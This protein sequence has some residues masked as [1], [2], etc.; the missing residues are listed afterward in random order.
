LREVFEY[1]DVN[2]C[3]VARIPRSKVHIGDRCGAS[4][5]NGYRIVGI[6]SLHIHE[7]RLIWEMLKGPIPAKM[8]VDHIDGN[9]SNNS[10]SNLRILTQAENRRNNH[11]KTPPNGRIVGISWNKRDKRW[12]AYIDIG[13]KHQFLGQ[14]VNIEEAKACRRIAEKQYGI[15]TTMIK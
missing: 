13:G 15:S 6:D 11:Y 1:D 12:H 9:R 10:I 7:H 3:L 8:Q 5:E 14:F 4:L 2:G